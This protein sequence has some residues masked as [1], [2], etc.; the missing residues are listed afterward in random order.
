MLGMSKV[1]A[2]LHHTRWHVTIGYTISIML[3]SNVNVNA[4]H[5]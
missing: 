2:V 5:Y 4:M 1:K 3:S